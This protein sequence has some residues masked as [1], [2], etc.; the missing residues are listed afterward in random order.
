M[1][2]HRVRDCIVALLIDGRS[3]PAQFSG[4]FTMD[5]SRISIQ[6]PGAALSSEAFQRARA[7]VCVSIGV[8]LCAR[9]CVCVCV[10]VHT[11]HGVMSW[12]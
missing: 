3:M 2:E 7:R 12:M 8:C 9:A 4:Q 6:R 10:C 11:F 5:S 1:L